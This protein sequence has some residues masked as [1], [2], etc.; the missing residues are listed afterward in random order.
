MVRAPGSLAIQPP[1]VISAGVSLQPI[2]V[3]SSYGYVVPLGAVP[4]SATTNQFLNNFQ[5]G[6]ND[7]WQTAC[8]GYDF[9]LENEEEIISG[10]STNVTGTDVVVLVQRS[11]AILAAVPQPTGIVAGIT[12]F[13]VVCDV[14]LHAFVDA[15]AT[16]KGSG[17]AANI[18]IDK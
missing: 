16:I 4:Y 3:G 11:A 13:G 6:V 8:F 5:W 17:D 10:L 7:P 2:G 18:S 9:D 1:D 14:F 15:I 12:N